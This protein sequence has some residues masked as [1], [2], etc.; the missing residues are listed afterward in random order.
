[1]IIDYRQSEDGAL[2][3]SVDRVVFNDPEIVKQVMDVSNLDADNSNVEKELYEEY[4]KQKDM[5]EKHRIK[6]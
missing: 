6:H 2:N 3:H 5:N 4:R 1:M